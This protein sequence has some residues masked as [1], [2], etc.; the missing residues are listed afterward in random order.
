MFQENIEGQRIVFTE[1]TFKDLLYLQ[2]CNNLE[3]I[4]DVKVTKLIIGM[5]TCAKSHFVD[6]FL[7]GCKSTTVTVKQPIITGKELEFSSFW[8][9]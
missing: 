4:V 2:N 8:N 6:F 9:H 3:I 7:E 5:I 1:A